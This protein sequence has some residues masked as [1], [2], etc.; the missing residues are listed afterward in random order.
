[1]EEMK[2][3]FRTVS[4]ADT[5]TD[6]VPYVVECYEEDNHGVKGLG[7]GETETLATINALTNLLIHPCWRCGGNCAYCAG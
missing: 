1:M 2:V 5:T 7:W 6:G 4:I 3:V